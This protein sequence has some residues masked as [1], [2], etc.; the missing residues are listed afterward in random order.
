MRL[1]L[2]LSRLL[3]LR[4]VAAAGVLVGLGL[5]LDLIRSA[6]ALV[7]AGGAG[8]LAHYAL[9]RA[10][11]IAAQVL[12]LAVLVGGVTGFL[13]LGRRAELTV[14]RAAGQSVFRL[15]ARLLPLAVALGLVQHLLIDR[16]TPWSERKLAEAYGEIAELDIPDKG[17]RVAGRIDGAVVI[18]RL[19]SRDG[20]MLAPLT[21][22]GL[23]AEG[24]VTGRIEA[25][26]AHYRSDH[27]ELAGVRRVGEMPGR[28]TLDFLWETAL[29]PATVLAMAG[30]EAAATSGEATAALQGLAV[31]TRSIGYYTTRIARSK[32]AYV[33]PAIMLLF[34]AFA[35]FKGPRGSAGLGMAVAGTVLGLCFVLL[36]GI[37]GSLGQLGILGPAVAAWTPAALFTIAG[38]WILLL[39]E[40]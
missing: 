4:I 24:Q 27:W 11:A 16:G 18:G 38:S 31:A 35:S 7:M 25:A 26:E 15:L 20:A 22:Y 28:T 17:A 13:A 30:G 6:D 23:D 37:F 10:P 39:K 21:I 34:A 36:D 29:A 32:V 8:A 2:Y 19:A 3:L 40:E 9:L 12:P 14:M 33:V 5:S 1:G